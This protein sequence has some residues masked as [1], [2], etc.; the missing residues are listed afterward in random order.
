M[1]LIRNMGMVW[2]GWLSLH[3]ST[4]PLEPRGPS[5]ELNVVFHPWHHLRLVPIGLCGDRVDPLGNRGL[6]AQPLIHHQ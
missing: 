2:H 6:L 5:G 3:L 1:V 4:L